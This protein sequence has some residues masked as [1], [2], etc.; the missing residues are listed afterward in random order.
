V[1]LEKQVKVN[2]VTD[3]DL[4][5]SAKKMGDSLDKNLVKAL[6]KSEKQF[7]AV[8]EANEK[9]TEN[10]TKG[11][12]ASEKLIQQNENIAESLQKINDPSVFNRVVDGLSDVVEATAAAALGFTAL[13]G[14]DILFNSTTR[15]VGAMEIAIGRAELKTSSMIAKTVLS[16]KEVNKLRLNL[17][18]LN[19]KGLQFARNGLVS[20]QNNLNL[21]RAAMTNI[22]QTGK[23]AAAGTTAVGQTFGAAAKSTELFSKGLIGSVA[24]A[25]VASSVFQVL[26]LKLLFADSAFS[27][28]AGV[29]L[30]ALSVALGGFVLLVQQALL[31]VG[32]LIQQIGTGLTEA[33]FKQIDAFS[34]AEKNTFAFTQ[35]V[36]SYAKS[37]DEA[38]QSLA[39]WTKFNEDA[40]LATGTTTSIM[41]ALVAETVSATEAFDLNTQQQELLI[42]RTIDLSERAHKPAIDTLT[43]LIGAMNGN[44]Q[45][46]IA[47][48]LHVNETAIAH[49]GLTKEVKE[50]FKSLTDAEKGQARFNVL[51]EQAGKA[52]GFAT[53]NAN[54]YSKGLKLQKNT[55]ITLNAELG[56]GAE[57]INGQVVFGLA[58][59]TT[60]LTEFAKPILPMLG[61]L[62]ALGGRLFQVSGFFIK[63]ALA[64][65]L[66]INA[67]KALNILLLRGAAAGVFAK[68]LPFINVSL[69][70]MARNLGAINPRLNS[71]KEVGKSSFQILQR[72]TG[73]ALRSLLGL[74]AGARITGK[75]FG[76]AFV[77]GLKK[78]A[79]AL[80]SFTAQALIFLATR[81]GAIIA[82][83]VVGFFA[84][85][86]AIQLIDA[87]TGVFT[88]IW[89]D[90]KESF[91]G[92]ATILE[93]VIGIFIE[94]ARVIGKVLGGVIKVFAALIATA[95]ANVFRLIQALQQLSQFGPDAFAASEESMKKIQERINKLNTA[96][97]K[98]ASQG[99]S[100]IGSAFISIASASEVSGTGLEKFLKKIKTLEAG[101][102]ELEKKAESAFKE[103]SSFSPTIQLAEFEKEEKKLL[104]QIENIQ[105]K[106]S[107]AQ[108]LLLNS[109]E[110]G[111]EV[112]KA[113]KFFEDKLRKAQDAASALAL[114]G[115]ITRRQIA[116]RSIEIQF[117]KERLETIS[118]TDEL[119]QVRLSLEE[120]FRRER[121]EILTANLLI[122]RGL[123]TANALAGIS[124]VQEAELDA[125]SRQLNA[126]RKNLQFQKTVAISIEQ[127]KQL[128]L[129]NIRQEGLA[130]TDALN[131]QRKLNQQILKAESARLNSLKNQNLLSAKEV[132]NKVIAIRQDQAN[133][134]FQMEVNLRNREINLLTNTLLE[135]R[136]LETVS[137]Q[138]G[139]LAMT[140]ARLNAD[141]IELAAFK[142]NIDAQQSLALTAEQQKQ[143]KLAQIRAENTAGTA[144]EAQALADLEVL[145]VQQQQAQIQAF[146]QSNAL[147]E[148]ETAQRLAQVRIESA[149]RV[150]TREIELAQQVADALGVTP[151]GLAKQQ[152]IL[153]LQEEMENAALRQ[154][155][156]NKNQTEAE[157]RIAR[158]Q[159]EIESDI[160]REKSKEEFA[161]R[162]IER[163]KF[164]GKTFE[165]LEKQRTLDFKVA[166]RERGEASAFFESEKVQAAVGGLNQLAT[167]TGAA[168]KKLFNI[169]KTAA[170]ASAA[171]NI[172]QGVT[173]ALKL[174]PII[175]PI[176]AAT[177]VAAG[178]LQIAKIKAQTFGGGLAG[179]S[180][181]AAP[182]APITG[183]QADEGLDFIPRSLDGKS[184]ILSKGEG[185]LQPEANADIREAAQKINSG[186]VG[187]GNVFNINI[188]SVDSQERVEEL[189]NAV[190]DILREKSEQGEPIIN[191]AGVVGA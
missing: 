153:L 121:V 186:E 171:V 47:L 88:D 161:K 5:S 108:I 54:L 120:S 93:P 109:G 114:K 94:L 187:G 130:P 83:V 15:A 159:L 87:E 50:N 172:A 9:A 175:G 7:L 71:L 129:A 78:A 110:S 177:T 37:Q 10:I 183:G 128:Q 163:L 158:E 105:K 11:A 86:K 31:L 67:V 164:A 90:L 125:R 44:S 30:V 60:A 25:S 169:G 107:E 168:S 160:R 142:A 95:V 61:F 4:S 134:V 137:A 43:A 28:A 26:G 24:R 181:G 91:A 81:I 58:R 27:K 102:E 98:L 18:L 157:F 189:A 145:I 166:S 165:A 101:L 135:K 79:L 119:N 6:E 147:S 41:Q 82:A 176:L 3:E 46:V 122:E 182:T 19:V 118:L 56:R 59:A 126:F 167:L 139:I 45:S 100:D 57:I 80:R 140:Q 14:V 133:A 151:E 49:S 65:G 180:T 32:G 146:R 85:R 111:K 66:V 143:L 1:A 17:G 22:I 33:S 73:N 53:L 55:Q 162:E 106:A 39:T 124:E 132:S 112:D 92:T 116:A 68:S 188:G 48:G 156:T 141:Q 155:L 40:S 23:A 34:E 16:G 144:S 127:E 21:T 103:A 51:M 150:A 38:T 89:N 64:I 70:Q 8:A 20:F 179:A 63:N 12:Q 29:G 42:Q 152:E 84:L 138:A 170:L 97:E 75:A 76:R 36:R 184:F 178:G 123:I 35:T 173:A 154:R 2:I 13:A 62:Q 77:N 117:E 96:A 113:V 52:A 99:L 115:A 72:Q 191:I 136:N 74:E 104:K 149:Q 190:K 185:V 69:L 148:Q 131:N 174:G